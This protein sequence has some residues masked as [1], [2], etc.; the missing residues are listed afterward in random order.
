M[1]YGFENGSLSGMG[2]GMLLIV[3]LI[4]LAGLAVGYIVGRSR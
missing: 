1:M 3:L 4:F 2:F